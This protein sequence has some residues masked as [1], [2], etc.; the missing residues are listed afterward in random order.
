MCIDSNSYQKL[1]ASCV[2]DRH[3]AK[4]FYHFIYTV[5]IYY[6]IVCVHI[7]THTYHCVYKYI[8]IYVLYWQNK[9][10]ESSISLKEANLSTCSLPAHP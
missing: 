4:Y 10:Y 5:Y 7:Y 6:C 9:G 8:H 3:C 1:D 2:L